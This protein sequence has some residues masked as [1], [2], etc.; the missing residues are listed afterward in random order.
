MNGSIDPYFFMNSETYEQ[1]MLRILNLMT[2]P[3]SELIKTIELHLFS[4][5]GLI[6][7]KSIKNKYIYT[8]S[9][10][11]CYCLSIRN[12]FHKVEWF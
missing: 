11:A 8:V 7:P 1:R 5:R 3:N 6:I 10:V 2:Y 9:S 4:S 12:D